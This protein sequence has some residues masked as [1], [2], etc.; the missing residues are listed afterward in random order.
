MAK[1]DDNITALAQMF[2]IL[3]D[4]TRVRILIELQDGPSNVTRLCKKLKAPQPTVS[5]HLSILRMGELVNTRRE[6]KEIFYSISGLERH[7]YSKSFG[8]LLKQAGGIRLGRLVLA[9]D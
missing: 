9:V 7:K 1:H 4:E 6:G 2:R 3:G 5:H 8:T